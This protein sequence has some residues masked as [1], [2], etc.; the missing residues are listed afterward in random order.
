MSNTKDVEKILLH[1][2]F[3]IQA[4]MESF[5]E[6][7]DRDLEKKQTEV[8]LYLQSVVTELS[9]MEEKEFRKEIEFFT[10]RPVHKIQGL[11]L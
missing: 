3:A 2:K 5:L 4:A 9:E 11:I 6:G 10:S 8:G 1:Y 7:S